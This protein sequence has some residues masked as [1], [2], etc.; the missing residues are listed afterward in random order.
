MKQV[1]ESQ[2][3]NQ[4]KRQAVFLQEVMKGATLPDAGK[5][6]GVAN[7]SRDCY[8][9][10]NQPE[11]RK[12]IRRTIRGL[13]D[14]EGLSVAYAYIIRVIRDEKEDKRLRLDA[15][16][17]I[18]SSALPALKAVETPNDDDKP[19][20]EMTNEELRAFIEQSES[21]LANRAKP[22]ESVKERGKAYSARV[23]LSDLL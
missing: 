15:A 13:A 4:A 16:K 9:L 11:V 22:I 5:A 17:F 1:T 23:T 3:A 18:Y 20:G 12:Q 19:T 8:P 7:P 10:L 6:A 2:A 21:E 14:T